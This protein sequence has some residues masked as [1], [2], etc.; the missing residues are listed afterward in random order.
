MSFSMRCHRVRDQMQEGVTK[1]TPGRESEEDL[2]SEKFIKFCSAI[3]ISVN[4]GS[5]GATGEVTEITKSSNP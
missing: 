3:V 2:K 5:Q 4:P 1:Q